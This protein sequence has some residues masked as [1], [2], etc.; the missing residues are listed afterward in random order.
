MRANGGIDFFPLPQLAIEFVHLQRAGGDLLK[1]L[2]VGAV[3]AFDG[4]VEFGGARWQH[5]QTQAALL[6]RLFEL[7][8]EFRAAVD[9]Q[10]ANRKRHAVLQGCPCPRET[11]TATPKPFLLREDQA[12]WRLR[13]GQ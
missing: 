1:F 4:A 12:G 11:A 5:E 13:R 2:S 7:G 6:T 9:L 8:G 10:S 3:S